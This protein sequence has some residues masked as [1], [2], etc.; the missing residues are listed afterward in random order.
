MVH[1]VDIIEFLFCK[2]WTFPIQKS[3]RV[4]EFV[5]IPFVLNL[6]LMQVM[7]SLL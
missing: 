5:N 7:S 3:T 1:S 6:E 4:H 2:P